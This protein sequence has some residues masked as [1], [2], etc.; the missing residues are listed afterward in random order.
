VSAGVGARLLRGGAE[1]RLDGAGVAADSG[2]F[3]ALQGGVRASTREAARRARPLAPGERIDPNSA[4]AEELDRLPKVGAAQAE[5]IV[6]WRTRHGRFGS[7]AG[8]DSVPGIGPAALAALAPWVTLPA[9]PILQPENRHSATP[10]APRGEASPGAPLNLNTAS[11]AELQTLPGI[12]AALARRIVEWRTQHGRFGSPGELQQVRG[13]GP[14]TAA[15]LA[16]RVTT[17]P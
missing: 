4:P 10:P 7:L 16:P 5:R 3:R 11:E 9:A 14:A 1:V 12:G 2:A 13:I 15:R 6:A 17:S 8:L